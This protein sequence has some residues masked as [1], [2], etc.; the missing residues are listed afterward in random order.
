MGIIQRKGSF[1]FVFKDLTLNN[2]KKFYFSRVLLAHYIIDFSNIMI[3]QGK[4]YSLSYLQW[5]V[6]KN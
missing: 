6:F 2:S 5:K 1:L 3:S 4:F